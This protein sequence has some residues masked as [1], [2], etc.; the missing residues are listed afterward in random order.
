ME[1]GVGRRARG[2]SSFVVVAAE[3]VGVVSCLAVF[4]TQK[5]AS[6]ASFSFFP[7]LLFRPSR[8]R[9]NQ[10]TLQHDLHL[11]TMLYR[12]HFLGAGPTPPSSSRRGLFRPLPNGYDVVRLDGT[13]KLARPRARSRACQA[14]AR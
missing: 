1:K 10:R 4:V 5:S 14:S 7:Q 3:E 2:R 6:L 11:A 9:E 12:F 8:F 13:T